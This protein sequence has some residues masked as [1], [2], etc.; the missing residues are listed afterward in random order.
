MVIPLHTTTNAN[1]FTA[2]MAPVPTAHV[3]RILHLDWLTWNEKSPEI[4][5]RIEESDK[6]WLVRSSR[7]ATSWLSFWC[8]CWFFRFYGWLFDLLGF[9]CDDPLLFFLSFLRMPWVRECTLLSTLHV[10]SS[11]F[12]GII[13]MIQK[14]ILFLR[15]TLT[16]V[17]KCIFTT[18]LGK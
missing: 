12:L 14:C 10:S 15:W 8:C 3:T 7:E 6:I 17:D 9:S 13:D 16:V 2:S 11:I 1:I 5:G 4:P 18:W